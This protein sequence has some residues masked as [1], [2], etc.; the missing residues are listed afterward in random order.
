M[1]PALL[2]PSFR[3][4]IKV[5][6]IFLLIFIGATVALIVDSSVRDRKSHWEP[7]PDL[8]TVRA[9]ECYY[10][11]DRKLRCKIVPLNPRETARHIGLGQ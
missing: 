8:S 7:T 6:F 11:L 5:V 1:K 9:E 3:P 4:W 10:G 2:E